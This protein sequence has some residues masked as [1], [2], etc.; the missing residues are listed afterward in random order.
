MK[1]K[2]P[3][4]TANEKAKYKEGK[5][6]QKDGI[7]DNTVPNV[8]FLQKNNIIEQSHPAGQ[9]NLFIQWKKVNKNKAFLDIETISNHTIIKIV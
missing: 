6:L 3:D 7:T 9:V 8:T 1:A 5:W 2:V 4:L